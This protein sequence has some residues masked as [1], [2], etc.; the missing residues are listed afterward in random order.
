MK[1]S[2]QTA[3]EFVATQME[4]ILILSELETIVQDIY[5]LDK[6]IDPKD[7]YTQLKMKK[8]KLELMDDVLEIMGEI[9]KPTKDI[10]EAISEMIFKQKRQML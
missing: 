2:V 3:T 9:K 10:D 7:I 5:D 6:G 4:S 1:E 8:K